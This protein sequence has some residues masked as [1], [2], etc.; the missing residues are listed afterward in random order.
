MVCYPIR[1][2]HEKM[3]TL[4]L[5]KG[6]IWIGMVSNNDHDQVDRGTAKGGDKAFTPK[7]LLITGYFLFFVLFSVNPRDVHV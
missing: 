4:R 6:W 5:Q 1:I 2:S 7:E 3:G